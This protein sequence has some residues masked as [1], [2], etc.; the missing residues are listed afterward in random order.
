MVTNHWSYNGMVTI[1]PYGL[2]P[3]VMIKKWICE[4]LY[5]FFVKKTI[6]TNAGQWRC[7]IDFQFTAEEGRKKFF[8]CFAKFCDWLIK[9]V[10][11]TLFWSAHQLQ[12]VT[13]M[14]K[15]RGIHWIVNFCKIFRKL[16]ICLMNVCIKF[17]DT[18]I[19]KKYIYIYMYET[20]NL[21]I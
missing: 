3:H 4:Q 12:V 18:Y 21:N 7:F 10:R 6:Y 19:C 2:L 1:Q 14:Q 9:L 13:S 20:A 5:N 11:A 15:Y 8:V 17:A 16:E